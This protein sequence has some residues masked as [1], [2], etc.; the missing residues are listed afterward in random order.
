MQHKAELTRVVDALAHRMTPRTVLIPSALADGFDYLCPEDVAPGA[1]V[2]VNLRGKPVVGMVEAGC[3]GSVAIE[4]L[5][6]ITRVLE[7]P[8]YPKKFRDWL[9]FVA[10]F[11]CAPR[12]SVLALTGIKQAMTPPKKP[13]LLEHFTPDLPDLSAHQQRAHAALYEA[14]LATPIVLNGVTGSGKTE[15]YFHAIAE[16]LARDETAQ[17][18]V[19]LPEIGLTHQ[20]LARFEAAF[21]TKPAC[22]H[23]HVTP[24]KRKRM[25]HAVARGELRVVVGARSALFL[26][27]A[28]LQMIV[29][30]EEHDTTYKQDDGVLYHARDM[31]VAR[32]KF[33]GARIVLASATPSL[34][35][36]YNIAQNRYQEVVL[37]TRHG[38]AKLPEV[39]LIDMRTQTL[40][41]G[42]FISPVLREAMYQTLAEG[43]QVLLFLNRRGYAPLMLCRGCGHRFMCPSCSAW[44]VKH[45]AAG[46]LQC[47]HCGYHAPLPKEC[48]SCGAGEEKLVACGPGV[49]RVEEEVRALFPE[50]AGAQ[51]IRVFSSD[52]GIDDAAIR[53]AISGEIRILIGTQML[54]K[55]HHF[56]Q[57]TLVGVIDADMGLAGGDLRGSEHTYQ[58]LHQLA[59]RAG[60][61]GKSGRV[62]LQSYAPDNAVMEALAHGSHAEFSSAELAVRKLGGWPPYGQ[63]A[64]IILDGPEEESVRRAGF[65]LIHTAPHD[66][67]IRVLGPAP[68]PL[69][70]LKGQY[71][72]RLLVKASRDIGLQRTL[73]TWLENAHFPRVRLK[74]DVNPYYF[75]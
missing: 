13:L 16:L 28:H 48:P 35:T 39:S 25:W 36:R 3:A 47:H 49:E 44:L 75:L 29:V 45:Q 19:M 11:T 17:I 21:G 59:G 52:E 4:K 51:A 26:P 57:L 31:A 18:L 1:L 2:E 6:P 74:L 58:L 9:E 43:D 67:R 61:A 22:W 70:K 42:E 68:A 34:E 60:R 32:A 14:D 72:Y 30:D 73:S 69:S 56:P 5:K 12:G 33:E 7:V 64:A 62:L 38:G 27:F 46:K 71:R 37:D 41:S 10:R 8:A 54:A 24:A 40:D 55:G 23:S 63:L 66:A 65:A 53:A 20:W 15:V 50:L